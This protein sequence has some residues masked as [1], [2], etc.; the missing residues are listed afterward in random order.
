[1]PDRFTANMAKAK[2]QD[3]I[4]I[5]YLRNGSGATAI[6]AFSTRAKPTATLSV[7]IAWE[8]LEAGVRADS[9]SV[10]NIEERLATL[11]A[12]PWQAYF[13]TKQ[14]VTADMLKLLRS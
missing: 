9:F 8:E 14:R 12:D 10:A 1:L 6:A 13:K 11:K 3:R 5:D 2:R 4:F 7:P